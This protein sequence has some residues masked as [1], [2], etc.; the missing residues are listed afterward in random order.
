M[1]PHGHIPARPSRLAPSRRERQSRCPPW[2]GGTA[3]T[4]SDDSPDD[5]RAEAAVVLQLGFQGLGS[6]VQEVVTRL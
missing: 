2:R 1:D 3:V 6:V 5:G 4:V